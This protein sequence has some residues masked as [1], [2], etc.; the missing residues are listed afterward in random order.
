M[1]LPG[2]IRRLETVYITREYLKLHGYS[3]EFLHYVFLGTIIYFFPGNSLS[4][5]LDYPIRTLIACSFFPGIMSG[6]KPLCRLKNGSGAYSNIFQKFLEQK[7]VQFRLSSNAKV[8]SRSEGE[9]KVSI[10]EEVVLFKYS[11]KKGTF[12]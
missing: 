1:L 4:H 7:G 11:K 9:V 10:N 2:I 6:D 12:I 3:N 8:L 5:Y